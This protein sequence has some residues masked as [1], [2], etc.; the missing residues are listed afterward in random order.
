[1]SVKTPIS[2]PKTIALKTRAVTNDFVEADFASFISALRNLVSTRHEFIYD[3]RTNMADPGWGRQGGNYDA[4]RRGVF[5][6]N[7]LT[8]EVDDIPFWNGAFDRSTSLI[9]SFILSNGAF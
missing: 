4:R 1:M 7:T 9:H 6:E 8:S 2:T 5:I 3:W